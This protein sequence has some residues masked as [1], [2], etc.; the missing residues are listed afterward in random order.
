MPEACRHFF[1]W[2]KLKLNSFVD[3]GSIF[4]YFTTIILITSHFEHDY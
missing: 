1:E 3:T 2:I 4:N